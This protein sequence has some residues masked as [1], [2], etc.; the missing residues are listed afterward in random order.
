MEAMSSSEARKIDDMAD[1]TLLRDDQMMMITETA[2]AGIWAA[3]LTPLDADLNPDSQRFVEHARDLLA[4]GCHGIVMFGTTGEAV[5]FSAA[6]RMVLLEAVLESGVPPQRL[7]IGTGCCALTD[8]IQL[9]AHALSLGCERVLMLP[10]FYFKGISEE[11]L[12]AS[13]AQV[14]EKVANPALQILLYHFPR[15]SGVPI[16]TGLIDRLIKAY[17]H[18]LLGCKDSSGDRE[19]TLN[20]IRRYPDLA[21]FPGS[22]SL[23]L[24][25]LQQGGAGCISATVNVNAAACRHIYDAYQNQDKE[26]PRLYAQALAMRR[27]LEAHPLVPVLKWIVARRRADSGWMRVRPPLVALDEATGRKLLPV[28]G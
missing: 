22:E 1:I 26:L 16:T 25:G 5:S 27:L 21:L 3:A 18:T 23:L 24:E 19:H 2:M 10:P 28:L 17:P 20:L 11:G 9:T 12:Y 4:Q 14:I 7:V 13:Y 6:E 8:T 15:L